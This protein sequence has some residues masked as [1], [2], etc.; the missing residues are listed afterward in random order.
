M[1]HIYEIKLTVDSKR[2]PHQVDSAVEDAVEWSTARQALQEALA[3]GGHKLT[4]L[5]LGDTEPQVSATGLAASESHAD[6]PEALS[7]LREIRDYIEPITPGSAVLDEVMRLADS[8]LKP[9]TPGPFCKGLTGWSLAWHRYSV[10]GGPY[11]RSAGAP[12]SRSRKARPAIAE[13]KQAS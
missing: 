5:C 2:P 10:H 7:T 11:P 1:Q 3:V 12:T 13:A 6:P 9:R 4:G 8:V